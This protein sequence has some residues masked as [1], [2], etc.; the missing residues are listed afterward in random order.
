[1]KILRDPKKHDV[2]TKNYMVCIKKTGNL[3]DKARTTDLKKLSDEGILK[4][5]KAV[6]L[7]N[8]KYYAF[9][10][11]IDSIDIVFDLRLKDL[12]KEKMR[13]YGKKFTEKSFSGIYSVLTTPDNLTYVAEE[14][15]LLYKAAKK[16]KE[17]GEISKELKRLEKY[18]WTG[19]GW[20]EFAIKDK[21]YFT[22]FI[23]K[24]LKEN[25]DVG[26][27][28]RQIKKSQEDIKIRKKS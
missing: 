9:T 28:I 10:M 27:E 6:I 8:M 5:Y 24:I 11:D 13:L 4:L 3:A 2:Y 20:N 21:R 12:I 23:K 19:L 1:M 22:A 7:Q 14:D 26:Q 16:Y 15:L 25:K 17:K 18:W